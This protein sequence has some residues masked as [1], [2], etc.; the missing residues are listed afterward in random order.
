[1]CIYFW[2]TSTY[3]IHVN[4]G[5]EIACTQTWEMGKA[6]GGGKQKE[7][8]WLLFPLLACNV[9]MRMQWCNTWGNTRNLCLSH[10]QT[11]PHSIL[12]FLLPWTAPPCLN[13]VFLWLQVPIR[14]LLVGRFPD[15]PPP[16]TTP[17][18]T[19]VIMEGSWIG[20]QE[21]YPKC[22][23]ATLGINHSWPQ[24]PTPYLIHT[25]LLA[26]WNL[27]AFLFCEGGWCHQPQK[28]YYTC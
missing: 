18:T 8:E 24:I 21:Q 3:C 12:L 28:F 4:E 6:S 14:C 1:M 27:S 22:A 10:S 17:P 26:K 2:D 25:L 13:Q 20:T 23:V 9:I 11:P 16:L 7:G 5:N 19:L 15:L